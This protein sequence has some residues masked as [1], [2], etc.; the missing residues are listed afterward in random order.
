[1]YRANRGPVRVEQETLSQKD[2]VRVAPVH[3]LVLEIV[4]VHKEWPFQGLSVKAFP[5]LFDAEQSEGNDDDKETRKVQTCDR[6]IL[7]LEVAIHELRCATHHCSDQS[8][9]PIDW[10][11]LWQDLTTT[12]GF[13]NSLSLL[14]RGRG[15]TPEKLYFLLVCFWHHFIYL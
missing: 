7:L 11:L 8:L 10:L 5:L 15:L 2:L 3:P 12:I 4:H 14:L 9:S 6:E 13:S 1:M